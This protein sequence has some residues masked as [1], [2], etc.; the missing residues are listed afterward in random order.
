MEALRRDDALAEAHAS[1]GLLAGI[2]DFEWDQSERELRTAIELN[3]NYA[4]AHH[5]LAARLSVSGRAAEAEAAI[6][7]ALKLDPF[8]PGIQSDAVHLLI[9]ARRY[10]D[11]IQR[12]RDLLAR[13][14]GFRKAG[15]TAL[16]R[17]YLSKGMHADAA[18]A[19]RVSNASALLGHACALGG[20][21]EQARAILAQL[22]TPYPRALVELGLGELERALSGLEQAARE[23]Y[24]QIV[25]V[26]V[27]P[28]FDALRGHP[29]F[30]QLLAR[31]HL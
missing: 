11:A 9:R 12:A 23:R 30:Q 6:A 28:M 29:R 16:G 26:G 2:W 20:D 19:F 31:M 7:G 1:L 5:W 27:E 10:D 8:S 3:P 4:S 15:H 17:A 18:A 14:P 22:S 25:Y 13:D 24:P 21:R